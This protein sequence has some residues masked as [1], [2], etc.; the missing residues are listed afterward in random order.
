MTYSR[1]TR[2]EAILD[3]EQW[4]NGLAVRLP[5]AAARAARLLADQ[6]V[7]ISVEGGRLILTPQGHKALSLADCL[8]LFDPA[9]HG[10]EAMPTMPVGREVR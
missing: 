5:A 6:R 7:Q 9:R 8:A 1:C 2:S 4:G 3:I 10:A